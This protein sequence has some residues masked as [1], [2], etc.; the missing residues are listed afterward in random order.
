MSHTRFSYVLLAPVAVISLSGCGIN[1]VPAAEESV[2]MEFN[3]RMFM[4]PE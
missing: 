4:R 1:S 3:E 2:T